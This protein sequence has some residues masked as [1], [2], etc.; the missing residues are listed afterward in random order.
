[1]DSLG[2]L[3]QRVRKMAWIRAM[4]LADKMGKQAEKAILAERGDQEPVEN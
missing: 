3:A 1:M 4:H 2:G